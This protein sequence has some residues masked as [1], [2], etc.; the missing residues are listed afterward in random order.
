MWYDL[1]WEMSNKSWDMSYELWNMIDIKKWHMIYDINDL[2]MT[3]DTNNLHMRY[4][5]WN[6]WYDLIHIN[7]WFIWSRTLYHWS[8]FFIYVNI[9]YMLLQ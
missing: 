7:I 5:I 8:I 3:Y 6:M 2:H 1:L 9:S 4:E